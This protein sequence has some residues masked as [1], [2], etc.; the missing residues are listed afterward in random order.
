MPR[1]DRAAV[2]RTAPT[3]SA[4]CRGVHLMFIYFFYRFFILLALFTYLPLA[5]RSVSN[6]N[7]VRVRTCVRARCVCAGCQGSER[8]AL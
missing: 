8:A 3:P 5:A 7:S 1:R 2:E 6:I 4:Q